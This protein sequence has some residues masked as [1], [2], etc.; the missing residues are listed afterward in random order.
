MVCGALSLINLYQ[1]LHCNTAAV[2]LL[3]PPVPGEPAA[4]AA[5]PAPPP[6]LKVKLIP[7]NPIRKAAPDWM[8]M[9]K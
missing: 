3:P 6:A 5:V 4:W 9:K 1:A 7:V 2:P 8:V